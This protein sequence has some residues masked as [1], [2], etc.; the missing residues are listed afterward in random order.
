MQVEGAQLSAL[1]ERL[2]TLSPRA[3]LER[4]YSIALDG[5]GRLV[6]S[7][8]RVAEGDSLELVLSDGRVDTRAERVR[9]DDDQERG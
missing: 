3:T 9:P 8:E 1:M 2:Y 4:G 5:D 7:V 6:A